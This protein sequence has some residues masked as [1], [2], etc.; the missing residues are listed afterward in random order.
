MPTTARTPPPLAA[1]M[2]TSSRPRRGASRRARLVAYYTLAT[3]EDG[4]GGTLSSGRA[5][6]T[7]EPARE[8]AG[9]PCRPAGA[10]GP[11]RLV[12]AL[13]EREL[14]RLVRE[15]LPEYMCPARWVAI[16]AMPRLP[17][18][19]LAA[20]LL[21]T[22]PAP[23]EAADVRAERRPPATTPPTVTARERG[24]TLAAAEAGHPDEAFATLARLLGE[25]LG[26][27][28]V[29][30]DDDF[31][32]LGGDSITAIQL[33][34][35]A[36]EAGLPLDV[37]AVT[38]Q[39]TL[40]ALARSASARDASA[41]P[42]AFAA[43]G[44][45]P[46]TPIQRWF[47]A[48]SHPAPA[49]WN[50][51]GVLHASRPLDGAILREAILEVLTRHPA[52]GSR[53][54]RRGGEWRVE[55]PSGA[56][57]GH[58][59]R[60]IGAD[61]ASEDDRRS[62]IAPLQAELRLEDGW[63]IRMLLVERPSGATVRLL[64]VAHH[65]ILDTLS[66]GTLLSEIASGYRARLGDGAGTDGPDDP[67][68]PARVSVPPSIGLRDWAHRLQALAD[69]RASPPPAVDSGPATCGRA[70]STLPGTALDDRADA[71]RDGAVDVVGSDGAFGSARPARRTRRRRRAGP[72]RAASTRGSR[73]ASAASTRLATSPVQEL[74]IGTLGQVLCDGLG[75]DMRAYRRRASRPRSARR[76]G[77]HE[78]QRRL[79][80]P[81]SFPFASSVAT[82]RLRT[83]G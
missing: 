62:S 14:E 29:R 69:S 81:A 83:G 78:R 46:P 20:R 28:D 1:P 68:H 64:W 57:P 18:G 71:A 10:I 37:A 39:P 48:R 49:H 26:V 3:P 34:S 19:K 75:R 30:P 27:H 36:R 42:A 50:L 13:D 51:A 54:V 70:A 7:G 23:A 82:R 66:V 17:N 80:H 79:V 59:V 25:L 35:R 56:P 43:H 32:E 53:F 58:V 22:P 21:P 61:A 74:L 40:G 72:S 33:V 52:L 77:R 6:A 76:S 44:E 45:A 63:L 73:A 60:S 11:A 8:E 41:P 55:I 16:D 12:D 5:S 38:S 4:P 67:G 2:P 65:L 9:E 47:L 24:A 31:F 15:S